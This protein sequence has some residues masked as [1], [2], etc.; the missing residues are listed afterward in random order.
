M[1]HIEPAG[2]AVAKKPSKAKEAWE[3][4][5]KVTK[6]TLA[7][8]I[9]V[10]LEDRKVDAPHWTLADKD[11]IKQDWSN[12]AWK[13]RVVRRNYSKKPAAYS[14]A[15]G[16]MKLDLE[17]EV[18][19]SKNVQA[20]GR[21][22]GTLG[23]LRV[24]GKCPTSVGTHAVKGLAMKWPAGEL[25]AAIGELSWKMQLDAPSTTLSL[26]STFVEIHF[27]HD[28][29][30]RMY[31]ASGVFAEV[32]RFAM[33]K[34]CLH[35]KKGPEEIAGT[36]ARRCLERVP[37]PKYD[38]FRGDTFYGATLTQIDARML[39]ASAPGTVLVMLDDFRIRKYAFVEETR[40]NCYD[41]SAAVQCVCGAV[42]L[43]VEWMFMAPFGYIN[44]TKLIGVKGKCNNPFHQN[45]DSLI[46]VPRDDPRRTAFGNHAFCRLAG[47]VLDAC[48]GPHTG[49]ETL[50]EYIAAAID[51][52]TKLNE[53]TRLPGKE[54]DAHQFPGVLKTK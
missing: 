52:K 11:G 26:G 43:S 4:S 51:H 25:G 39:G 47:K 16:D 40:A 30:G 7:T 10:T 53:G 36:A 24:E 48:A 22:V 9:P 37:G 15:A 12:A 34:A 27:L 5:A 8:S 41:Q 38:V 29:P 54:T 17:V 3:L 23:S 18:K 1:A 6:L 21:I 45:D 49:T 42:G 46:W 50:A 32:L 35:G 14:L 20:E 31:P 28:K 33:L 2:A 44:S 13:M 19:K